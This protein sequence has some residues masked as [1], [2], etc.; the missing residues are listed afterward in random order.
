MLTILRE[1]RVEMPQHRTMLLQVIEVLRRHDRRFDDIERR[2]SD[3][4]AEIELMLKAELLG[5]LTHFETRTD[6]R[7][8]E[9]EE[10]LSAVE[11]PH[12]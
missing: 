7:I 6:T 3:S 2:I 4:R 10:R 9:L 12:G 5:S 11:H 8:A 1:F